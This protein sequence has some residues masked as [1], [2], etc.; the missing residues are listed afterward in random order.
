[1]NPG[2]GS[3]ELH[4][5]PLEPQQECHTKILSGSVTIKRSAS[6]CKTG[7]LPGTVK[8]KLLPVSITIKSTDGSAVIKIRPE[9]ATNETTIMECNTLGNARI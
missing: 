5:T 9:N 2:W 7:L 6:D 8:T 3:R 1:M 4:E